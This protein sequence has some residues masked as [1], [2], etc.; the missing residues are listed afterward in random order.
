M[1]I[2]SLLAAASSLVVVQRQRPERSS[3]T[4]HETLSERFLDGANVR[5]C[6]VSSRPVFA[7]RVLPANASSP[8]L[9]DAMERK[10]LLVRP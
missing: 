1:A 10:L 4:Q 5:S 7:C 2:F 3:H 8:V 6:Q 9:R